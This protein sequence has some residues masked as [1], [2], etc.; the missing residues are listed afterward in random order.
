MSWNP[1]SLREKIIQT[2]LDANDLPHL[3]E[4]V[5][6]IMRLTSQETTPAAAV[7]QVILQSPTLT[8]K[9]LRYANS[10][11]CGFRQEITSVQQAVVLLGF[12]A[13]RDLVL[14]LA[15]IDLY[16]A[17]RAVQFAYRQF[18][19]LAFQC[20]AASHLIA[21]RMGLDSEEVFIAGLLHDIGTLLLG[22]Y[23]SE[24][25]QAVFDRKHQTGEPITQSE[26]QILGLDHTL[27]GALL[28]ARWRLPRM[29]IDVI[30]HHHELNVEAI[31]E[32]TARRIVPIIALADRIVHLFRRQR[33][34]DLDSVMS[35]WH[36]FF[37][38]FEDEIESILVRFPSHVANFSFTFETKVAEVDSFED[39][40]SRA[41]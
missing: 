18:M 10:P 41:A 16:D 9:V 12:G 33:P 5:F 38:Q 23:Q 7:A 27:V 6:R 25:I 39:V 26:K 22:Q 11:L 13:V 31:V 4:T 37:K 3:P 1:D 19:D 15:L 32:P 21:T 29:F 34:Q 8:A 17:S 30:R 2:I 35:C 20:A 36:R 40:A 14:G 24:A 28:A